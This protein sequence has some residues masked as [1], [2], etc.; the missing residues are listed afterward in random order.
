MSGIPA[1]DISR[2]Q[3]RIEDLAAIGA[4]EGGGVRR[5]A[6]SDEDREARDYL[7]KWAGNLGLYTEIDQIGNMF[8]SRDPSPS[9]ACV[10][11]GS[12]LDTVGTGGLYDGSL[13]VIAAM[14]VMEV[15]IENQI[16]TKHPFRI[17]NFTNEEGVRFTPDMMGSLAFKNGISVEDLYR[18][19][20]VDGRHNLKE[21]LSRIGY[22]GTL[23]PGHFPVSH[24]IELHIEQ[25]PVLESTNTDIGAVSRVQGIAWTE[26]IFRGQAAHAGTT[27][28]EHRSDAG[29]V[30]AR[31]N[32]FLRE[33]AHKLNAVGTIGIQ[34]VQPNL[35]NVVPEKVRVTTDIRHPNPDT[36]KRF[37][38]ET[39]KY[40]ETICEEEQV[41]FQRRELVRIKP[42]EFANEMVQ[43]ITRKSESLG[44]SCKK[45]ISGAGHDAQ[46]MAAVCPTAMIF[47]TSK[48]GISHNIREFTALEDAEKGINVLLQVSLE[49]LN[50]PA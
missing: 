13:G 20:S 15:L 8:I 49:L 6:L 28:L 31:L 40:I 14:E 11:T 19:Q 3:K 36:F 25:G 41:E 48:D 26:Y 38:H 30:A 2:V 29:Y 12:H 17:V 23:T 10:M 18:I 33:R 45:M 42:V 16:E 39:D 24:F 1:I 4:L 27:P 32:T 34:E 7:K 5:L 22:Q 50:R 35:I 46:M 47:V 21:E 44:Y 37:Q 9:R 43:L